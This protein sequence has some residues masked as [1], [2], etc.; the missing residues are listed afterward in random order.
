MTI[1]ISNIK[2]SCSVTVNVVA[3]IEVLIIEG[4]TGRHQL[5]QPH[6]SDEE[7]AGQVEVLQSRKPSTLRQS[8]ETHAV[9]QHLVYNTMHTN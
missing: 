7:A 2:K 6:L 8:P 1:S 3:V 4:R 5:L 9:N